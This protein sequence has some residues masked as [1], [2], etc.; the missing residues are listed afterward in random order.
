MGN[1]NLNHIFFLNTTDIVKGDKK[2]YEW[3]QD[4]NPKWHID[5]IRK[6]FG[7]NAILQ[8]K[9]QEKSVENCSGGENA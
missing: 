7:K 6:C 8:E 1:Y 2:L 4:F 5:E 3:I 9:E